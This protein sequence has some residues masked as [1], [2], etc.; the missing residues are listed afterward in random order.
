MNVIKGKFDITKKGKYK[1][2]EV[3]KKLFKLYYEKWKDEFISKDTPTKFAN[4]IVKRINSSVKHHCG[5]DI[6][7]YSQY[8]YGVYGILSKQ[9]K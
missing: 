2:S 3:S 6:S 9:K 1:K 5:I 8:I 7:N 4:E